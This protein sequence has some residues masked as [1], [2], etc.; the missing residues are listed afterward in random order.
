MAETYRPL[1][2]SDLDA[3][4]AIVSDWDVVRQLGSWPWPPDR[5][6]SASRARPYAGDGFVWAICRHGRMIGTVGV[7]NGELGYMLHP[8][9]HRQGIMRRAVARALEEGFSP[10]RDTIHAGTW[11]DNDASHALLLSFGFVHWQTTYDRQVARRAPVLG[12]WYRLTRA[13]WLETR[14][15]SA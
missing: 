7:T 2:E 1:R 10:G 12:R 3:L 13:R 4:H 15:Q 6:L 14:A 5:T 8:D 9:F 11:A